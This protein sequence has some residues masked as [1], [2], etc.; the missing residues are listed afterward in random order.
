MRKDLSRRWRCDPL[1]RRD[2]FDINVGKEERNKLRTRA[3]FRE[4]VI[5]WLASSLAFTIAFVAYMVIW[6]WMGGEPWLSWN[7]VSRLA[8]LTVGVALVVQFFYGGLVYLV[9]TGIGLWSFWT[10]AFAYLVP[11]WLIGTFGIDTPREARGIIAWVVFVCIVAGVFR[12]LIPARR[13][14]AVD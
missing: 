3:P 6:S 2:L 1:R 4:F 14:D 7:S 13:G 5:A 11:I 12:A 10:I 8:R 9:L